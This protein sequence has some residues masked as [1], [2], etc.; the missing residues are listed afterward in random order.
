ML[1]VII[2]TFMF[3]P[4]WVALLITAGLLRLFAKAAASGNSGGG[5]APAK[6][7]K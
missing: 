5:S 7:S 6:G 1:G 2:A 4:W 3:L